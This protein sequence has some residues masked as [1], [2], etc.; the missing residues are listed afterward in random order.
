M[1]HVIDFPQ[2]PPDIE[3]LLLTAVP[4]PLTL[5][6]IQGCDFFMDVEILREGPVY[7]KPDPVWT[8]EYID[9]SSLVFDSTIV[10]AAG[11]AE[12]AFG[13]QEYDEAGR[14]WLTCR[15]SP[16]DTARM[17]PGNYKYS[18]VARHAMWDGPSP[19]VFDVATILAGPFNVKP[20]TGD[21]TIQ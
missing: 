21:L 5:E 2:E 11:F 4:N 19:V 8:E 7:H 14:R 3:S 13:I 12:A 15:L 10:S 9:T 17:I 20:S 1:K 6:V 16:D 18:I